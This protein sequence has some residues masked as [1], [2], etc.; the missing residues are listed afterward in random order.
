M[1][2]LDF[3]NALFSKY[4]QAAASRSAL[5]LRDSP[6]YSF[7]SSSAAPAVSSSC[8]LVSSG[9]HLHV[10][11][12][13]GVGELPPSP[14]SS[15]PSSSS[16]A[17]SSS[18]SAV[19]LSLSGLNRSSGSIQPCAQPFNPAQVR[20]G[21]GYSAQGAGSLSSSLQG[22][23]AERYPGQL[24][25]V[26]RLPEPACRRQSCPEQ[27]QFNEKELRIYPWMRSSGEEW[28]EVVR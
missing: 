11:N 23:A 16:L 26:T 9:Y 21:G 14:F 7:P 4:Q 12:K 22:C 13:R 1:S 17:P 6:T 10:F 18:S 20:T 24:C 28:E 15:S 27:Q 19:C 25:S 2:T 8:A 5:L 3:T